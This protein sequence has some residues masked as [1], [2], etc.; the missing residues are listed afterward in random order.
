MALYRSADHAC[1][2]C[3]YEEENVL[4][5]FC[6]HADIQIDTFGSDRAAA[7]GIRPDCPLPEGMA[8]ADIM[9]GLRNSAETSQAIEE[10]GDE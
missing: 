1:R 6:N 3:P 2:E 10:D 4:G 7:T 9:A 8:S 5:S